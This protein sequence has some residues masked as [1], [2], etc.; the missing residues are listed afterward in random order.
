[1]KSIDPD[2]SQELET[3]HS[4]SWTMVILHDYSSGKQKLLEYMQC[5][6]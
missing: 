4:N 6:P 1:M 2:T 5:Q 3:E